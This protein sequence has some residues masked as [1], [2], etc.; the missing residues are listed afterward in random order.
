MDIMEKILSPEGGWALKEAL[1][2]SGQSTKPDR[3][4]EAFGQWD[5]WG[6]P[7]QDLEFDSMIHGLHDPSQLRIFY[8]FKQ[9][10]FCLRL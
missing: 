3:A 4:Q 7:V 1:Q 8:D 5:S 9:D 10:V 2:G 6:C